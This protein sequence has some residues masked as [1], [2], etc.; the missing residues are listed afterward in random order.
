VGFWAHVPH[1][2]AGPYVGGA[3]ALVERVASHLG[4][5]IPTRALVDEAMQERTRLDEVVAERPEAQ[6]YLD[7]LESLPPPEAIPSADGIAAEV[8]RFLRETT[9]DDRNPFEGP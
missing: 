8:E 4:V 5:S 1:Y 6:A 2:V 7:R 9:G 3:L